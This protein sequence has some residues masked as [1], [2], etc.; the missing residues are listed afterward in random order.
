MA[1]NVVD[2]ARAE[3]ANTPVDGLFRADLEKFYR[4]ELHSTA[5]TAK[6][7]AWLWVHHFGLH[8]VASH[9]FY[10]YAKRLSRTRPIAA[11]PALMA[12]RLFTYGVRL[13]H[14]VEIQAE[15]GPGFY[16]GHAGNIYI[17]ETRIG[18]NFS[19]THNV[20]VG[21]GHQLGAQ[22]IP[23]IGDDVWI[24][25]GSVAAGQIRIGNG[26]TVANGSMISRNVPDGCLVAGNPARPVQN[27]YDNGKLLGQPE[28][29]VT[30]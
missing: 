3:P 18:R 15:I 7:R 17:G 27:G 16:I 24:G 23:V 30:P 4:I 1:I 2:A 21:V 29:A 9:R 14:H 6:Q 11:A 5:P 13:I 10:R 12:A 28:R 25:T 20:T 26:V 19:V 22:G 8:C